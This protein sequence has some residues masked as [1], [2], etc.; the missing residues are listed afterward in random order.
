LIIDVNDNNENLRVRPR[1]SNL[2]LNYNEEKKEKEN[3][4]QEI[5]ATASSIITILDDENSELDCDNNN[6]NEFNNSYLSSV[7]A[8]NTSKISHHYVCGWEFE[9]DG[10][11]EQCEFQNSQFKTKSRH[12]QSHTNTKS[13]LD[14]N[15]QCSFCQV[16]CAQSRRARHMRNCRSK[17][18]KTRRQQNLPIGY[19]TKLQQEPQSNSRTSS[20]DIACNWEFE[21]DE[22]IEKS[23]YLTRC[24]RESKKHALIHTSANSNRKFACSLCQAKFRSSRAG[25]TH[26]LLSHPRLNEIRVAAGLSVGNC[27]EVNLTCDWEFELDGKTE[28][29]EY[30]SS[31]PRKLK[32]HLLFHSNSAR[33]KNIHRKYRC[34]LCKIQ[35]ITLV[36]VTD[37]ISCCH[38]ELNKNR[39]Q[40]GLEAGYV[41]E[42]QQQAEISGSLMETNCSLQVAVDAGG[43][44]NNSIPTVNN[45]EE[46]E[47]AMIIDD[48]MNNTSPS[49]LSPSMLIIPDTN[50]IGNNYKT[51]ISE[52]NVDDL[53]FVFRAHKAKLPSDFICNWEFELDGKIEKCEFVS[54]K[55]GRKISHSG[56]HE[57]N[58]SDRKYRKYRCSLCQIAFKALELA[59]T[60]IKRCHQKL[61]KNRKRLGLPVGYVELSQKTDKAKTPTKTNS[62]SP[63]INPRQ[64]SLQQSDNIKISQN[65]SSARVNR[66]HY[67]KRHSALDENLDGAELGIDELVEQNEATESKNSDSS[68]INNPRKRGRSHYNKA[69][70]EEEKSFS[71][72]KRASRS[73]IILDDDE[74]NSDRSDDEATLNEKKQS[75][76]ELVQQLFATKN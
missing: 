31:A 51:N 75:I 68:T 54:R 7:S 40:R 6:L 60:H 42:I 47:N 62:P 23:E 20:I 32:K 15:Y 39:L 17:L 19:F 44:P 55:P 25:H 57:S 11:I 58:Q 35:Y 73:K 27:Q 76:S 53:P 8:S 67:K 30:R 12:F 22:K 21:L 46:K 14:R 34:S 3:L 29:C 70:G 64:R 10:K 69:D 37:H 66:S 26:I 43:R 59:D 1:R 18:N 65:S 49:S 2:R 52:G 38:A 5:L 50:S 4:N 13:Y 63:A 61:N 45:E 48:S 41:E 71:S 28:K 24:P 36:S 56:C 9:L 33:D 74:N 16:Q 72:N